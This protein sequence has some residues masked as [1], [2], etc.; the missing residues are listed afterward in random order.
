M[1][2]RIVPSAAVTSAAPPVRPSGWVG[3]R[4]NTASHSIGLPLRG[5]RPCDRLAY[6]LSHAALHDTALPGGMPSNSSNAASDADQP[7]TAPPVPA[8][9]SSVLVRHLSCNDRSVAADRSGRSRAGCAAQPRVTPSAAQS[10][11]KMPSVVAAAASRRPPR[12]RPRRPPLRRC[13]DHIDNIRT[14]GGFPSCQSTWRWW[15]LKNRAGPRHSPAG[16]PRSRYCVE[17]PVA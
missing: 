13:G 5:N 12:R 9:A 1:T 17:H 8:T 3:I 6:K 10:S 15:R 14:F 7:Q 11:P 2:S 4:R 16:Q